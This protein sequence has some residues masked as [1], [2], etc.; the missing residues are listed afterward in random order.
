MLHFNVSNGG[1]C[2]SAVDFALPGFIPF[3]FER[4]YKSALNHCGYLGWNWTTPLDSALLLTPSG[5][6]FRDQWGHTH[7]LEPEK[8]APPEERLFQLADSGRDLV[9]TTPENLRWRFFDSG[10]GFLPHRIEDESENAI[11]FEYGSNGL[12]QLLTDTLGRRG[13]RRPHGRESPEFQVLSPPG[14]GRGQFPGCYAVVPSHKL[15]AVWDGTMNA[16]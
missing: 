2:C 4:N 9:V 11:T 16:G 13:D 10:E 1:V 15:R 7:A 6:S 3:D 12:I 14:E 5:F 8:K